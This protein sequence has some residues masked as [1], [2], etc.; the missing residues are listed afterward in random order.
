MDRFRHLLKARSR[1][2]GVFEKAKAELEQLD[3]QIDREHAVCLD[4]VAR[5]RDLIEKTE[6]KILEEKDAVAFL[7]AEQS[8]TRET[9]GKIAAVTA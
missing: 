4:A 9:I 7:K 1:A 6:A 3:G 2:L 5:Y 8:R